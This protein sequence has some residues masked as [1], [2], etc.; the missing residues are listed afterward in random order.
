MTL[1]PVTV[2]KM[3]L[4]GFVLVAVSLW[5]LSIMRGW[6]GQI[7]DRLGPDAAQWLWLRVFRVAPS[8]E[9]CVWF[10]NVMSLPGIVL[11]L[12]VFLLILSWG[13]R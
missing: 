9:S 10:L 6:A 7:Y 11:T 3:V 5:L 13:F 1:P 12:A 8:R 4:A 2:E